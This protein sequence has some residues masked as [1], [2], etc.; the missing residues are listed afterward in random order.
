MVGAGAWTPLFRGVRGLIQPSEL[1]ELRGRS[2]LELLPT[3]QQPRFHAQTPCVWES[4]GL[5][6]AA[7]EESSLVKR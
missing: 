3:Q 4:L 5:D 2:E 7:V 6:A 1:D